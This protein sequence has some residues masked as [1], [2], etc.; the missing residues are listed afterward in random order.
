MNTC[1]NVLYVQ[2]GIS[3]EMKF[4]GKTTEKTTQIFTACWIRVSQKV[5]SDI[6]FTHA[7]FHESI[8]DKAYH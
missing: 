1:K 6:L 5:I 3:T 4:F 7:I 8:G 2:D